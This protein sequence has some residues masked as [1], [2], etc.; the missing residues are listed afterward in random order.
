MRPQPSRPADPRSTTR[1][2]PFRLLL[3]RSPDSLRVR[4]D[5]AYREK[6]V[7]FNWSIKGRSPPPPIGRTNAQRLDKEYRPLL[8][9]RRSHRTGCRVE[10]ARPGLASSRRRGALEAR[11]ARALPGRRIGRRRETSRE[12][13]PPS[14]DSTGSTG[15]SFISSSSPLSPWPSFWPAYSAALSALTTKSRPLPLPCR[16]TSAP[17]HPPPRR[18]SKSFTP[19]RCP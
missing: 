19:G 17:T 7:E 4:L 13:P 11:S 14:P 18:S 1:P 2:A 10:G 9:C 15:P 8:T 5:S 3:G 6:T 16:P 12:N